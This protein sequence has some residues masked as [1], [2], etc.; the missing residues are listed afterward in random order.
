[1]T[2]VNPSLP[3]G[4]V[5][6]PVVVVP[7]VAVVVVVN[8]VVVAIVVGSVA[9]PVVGGGAMVIVSPGGTIGV[10][11]AEVAAW[12]VVWFADFSSSPVAATATIAPAAA[13]TRSRARSAAQSQTGDSLV[14]I[15]RR[16]GKGGGSR[17]PHSRQYS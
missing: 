7:V 5:V 14:Q 4:H 15:S 6:R 17:S 11:G 3:A 2:T 8:P 13:A 9:I 16:T 12:L 10:V 1:M